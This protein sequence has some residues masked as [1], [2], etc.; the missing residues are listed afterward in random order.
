MNNSNNNTK[1]TPHHLKQRQVAFSHVVIVDFHVGPVGVL[2][3][4]FDGQAVA[5]VVDL[6]E[7]ERLLRGGVD[8]AVELASKQINSHDAEDEPKDQTHQQHVEDGG[9]RSDES[10]HHHLLK[11]RGRCC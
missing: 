5:L 2:C 3:G 6:T 9:D 7:E 10:V 1:S 8:A 11:R 4:F